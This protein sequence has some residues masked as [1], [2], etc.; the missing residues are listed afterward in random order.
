[1]ERLRIRFYGDVQG[2]GFRYRAYHSANSLGLTGWVKNCPDGTVLCEVQ[3]ERTD[4]D[5]MVEMI[6]SG[7]YVNITNMEIKKLELSESDR[8]FVI[9]D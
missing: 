8:N 6:D 7:R 1:M 3:G 9:G 5:K 4:I 2:V